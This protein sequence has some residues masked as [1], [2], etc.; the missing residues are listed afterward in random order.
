MQQNYDTSLK[1]I[2]KEEGGNDDDPDDPGGRTS[3]GIIQ[4]EWNVFCQTHP[5]RPSDVWKASDEDVATIYKEQY[6]NPY[7]DR[8]PSGV[9][10]V[11][12][13]T[14]VNSGRTQ[15]VKELQRALGFKPEDVDGMMGM[16]TF[17]ALSTY[18]DI[19]G[20]IRDMCER[21][22]AYY[23]QLKTFWKYG[24][25]WLA[26]TD[27][28]EEAAINMTTH[29][30]TGGKAYSDYLDVVT[31]QYPT[32]DTLPTKPE[33]TVSAKADVTNA[34]TPT[35]SPE[36][37]GSATAGVGSLMAIIS[38][39]KQ[40]LSEFS[41]TFQ[42]IQYILLALTLIGICYTVYSSIR[43]NRIKQVAG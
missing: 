39:I 9:D 8:L 37:S 2:L 14:S 40:Q 1:L 27:R 43:Q 17:S 24:K 6:W 15:A 36:A 13:N 20:L 21:R 19:P 12:F 34:A 3:R 18:R 5:D 31:L 38:Q 26:R 25:G 23:R 33:V 32:V 42:Y 4:R 10:L 29:P 30:V 41:G 7:C 22:R 16:I 35:L 11:F 28:I